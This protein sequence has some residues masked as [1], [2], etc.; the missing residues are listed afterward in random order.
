MPHIPAPFQ[1]CRLSS[2]LFVAA[3]A[4]AAALNNYFQQQTMATRATQDYLHITQIIDILF[5]VNLMFEDDE[6]RGDVPSV[7]LAENNP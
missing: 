3:A 4:A 2:S 5:W 7:S 1:G 6:K